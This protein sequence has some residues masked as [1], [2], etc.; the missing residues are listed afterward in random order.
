MVRAASELLL[1]DPAALGDAA[2]EV[3]AQAAP[4][5]FSAPEP[6][7]DHRWIARH[8]LAGE[9]SAA[10]RADAIRCAADRRSASERGPMLLTELDALVETS[11]A[12]DVAD[13][14]APSEEGGHVIL[15]EVRAELLEKAN[16]RT[17]AGEA[18]RRAA[19]LARDS[20]HR[21]HLHVSAARNLSAAGDGDGAILALEAAAEID[22]TYSNVFDQ[23]RAHYQTNN[24]N[25][26]L[27]AL[28]ERRVSA[29]ADEETLLSL[30]ETQAR[31]K[32]TLGDR[33]GAKEALLAALAIDP[34]HADALEKLALLCLEDEDWTGAAEALVRFAHLRQTR[35]HLRW[36]FFELGTIYDLHLPD[37]KRAEAAYRRVL[38]IEPDDL[39][40]LER[41]SSFYFKNKMWSQA[42]IA[43]RELHAREIDPDEKTGHI[44]RL[45]RA[46]EEDGKLRPA[47]QTLDEE[48]KLRPGDLGILRAL[49]DLYE[50]QNAQS[51]LSMHLNRASGDFRRQIEETPTAPDAWT[52]L[53]EVLAWRGADDAGRVVA[54]TAVATGISEI[55]LTNRLDASGGVPGGGAA[56]TDLELHELL[57]P[58]IL[59]PATFE[60][61]RQVGPTLDKLLPFDARAWRTERVERKDDPI[62][63]E[64]GRIARWFGQAEVQ[65]LISDAAPKVCVPVS[66]DP[67]TIVVGRE[68]AVH[69]SAEERAFLFARAAKVSA[70]E[71]GV[72]MRSPPRQLGLQLAALVHLY[73][74]NHQPADFE[75]KELEQAVKRMSRAL[76]RR[77]RDMLGPAAVEMG[78]TQ[79]FDAAR[80]GLAAAQ[81]GDRAGLLAIG[82]VPKA[83][84]ALLRLA[85]ISGAGQSADER[86]ESLRGVPE[87]LDLVR[88]ASSDAHFEARRRI[89][90]DRA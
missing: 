29:G 47:E 65:V 18:F 2:D 10:I 53:A 67:L 26:K 54:S 3:L 59:T 31:L 13:E 8:I 72:A 9:A 80:I 69:A 57:A 48:R 75:A 35:D 52:G 70:V 86:V 4:R 5:V 56:A 68:V 16:D 40:A 41:L 17:A 25:R 85:G 64:A 77:V 82:N 36:V 88:F 74:P 60:V 43:T 76:P 81:L 30:H 78:G 7:E 24:E 22:V 63:L 71:L 89:G 62:L 61:F 66:S 28:A 84:L 23:L 79:G 1:G 55:T 14:L 83:V 27:A 58:A 15:S 21:L 19:S 44:I 39:Q 45:S 32:T 49:A 50:R 12:A 6:D 34:K 42:V 37:A 46:Y 20:R 11:S 33:A 38:K 73:D 90:A 87:A 51:A